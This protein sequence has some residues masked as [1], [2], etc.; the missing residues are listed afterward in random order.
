MFDRAPLGNIVKDEEF[1]VDGY[2]TCILAAVTP[3]ELRAKMG[4]IDL[5]NGFA[6]R[7]L[8]VASRSRARLDWDDETEGDEFLRRLMEPHTSRIG[9]R[10]TE[11]TARSNNSARFRASD[12]G[13]EA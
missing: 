12:S 11:A 2:H 10:L 7:F 8:Y 3:Q 5:V 4:S 9:R 1:N 13:W 6:N